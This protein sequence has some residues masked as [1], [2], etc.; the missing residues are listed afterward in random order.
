MSFD[1]DYDTPM[2]AEQCEQSK[3]ALL[4]KLGMRDMDQLLKVFEECDYD[5][6]K[7]LK[8][9]GVDQ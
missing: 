4:R 9:L 1:P 6:E 8:R 2:T 7:I 5:T 3:R